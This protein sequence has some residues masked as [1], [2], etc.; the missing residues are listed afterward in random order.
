[1]R[2]QIKID[3]DYIG[4]ESDAKHDSNLYRI[5]ITKRGSTFANVYGDKNKIYSWLQNVHQVDQ[6][7]I[8]ELYPQLK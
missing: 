6:S 3:V 7:E 1:M 5:K 8:L 2:K 4:S